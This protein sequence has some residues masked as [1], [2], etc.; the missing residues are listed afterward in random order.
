M[1]VCSDLLELLVNA[2]TDKTAKATGAGRAGVDQILFIQGG[3][4]GTHDEWDNKLV[5]SLQRGLGQGCEMRYPR[6]PAED[7][8]N[9][10]TWSAAI[11]REIARLD[12]G[13][14]VV[15]HSIGGTVLI[16]TLASQ[17]QLLQGIAAICLIAAPFVG[18]GGWPSEEVTSGPGWARPLMD[19]T[20]YLYQGDADETTPMTHADLYLKAMP[21]A[22]L[23]RL[24]GRDHQLG[25][26]LSEVAQDI[27]K[28]RKPA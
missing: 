26:D 2:M 12:T 18:D 8:P 9:F 27:T 25:D 1:G 24:K 19:A 5:A 7:D 28:A 23:R 13:A 14:I 16:H 22:R 10:A 21:H 4:E 15:G 20:V 11:G 6:M 3:G 17:P